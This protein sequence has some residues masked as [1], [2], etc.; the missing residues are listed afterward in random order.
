MLHM[1]VHNLSFNKMINKDEAFYSWYCDD[2][3]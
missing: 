2:N 3:D 1:T